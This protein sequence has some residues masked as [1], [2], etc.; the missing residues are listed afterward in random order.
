MIDISKLDADE[1]TTF[2]VYVTGGP[3]VEDSAGFEVVG[4]NSVE[5]HKVQAQI[6]AKAMRDVK[7]ANFPDVDTDDGAEQAQREGQARLVSIALSCTVDFFGFTDGG[8][9]LKFSRNALEKLLT[10]RPRW[11]LYIA[12]AVETEANFT[13][14]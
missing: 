11:A 2:K 10:V 8:K 6:A 13:K 1:R 3:G 12:R 5:F 14:G 7:N 4:P 9:P